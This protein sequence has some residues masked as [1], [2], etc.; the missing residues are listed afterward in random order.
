M[1]GD[2]GEGGSETRKTR[3]GH[4]DQ[5]FGFPARAP[6]TKKVINKNQPALI[7]TQIHRKKPFRGKN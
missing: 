2:D 5:N 7:M 1:S 4:F 6:G 3:P